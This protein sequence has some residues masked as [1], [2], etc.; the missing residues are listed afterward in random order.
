MWIWTV[1]QGFEE[2]W[3][4]EDREGV[5]GSEAAIIDRKI[6]AG[7]VGVGRGRAC[8]RMHA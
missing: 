8:T 5:V 1:F 4:L 6:T 7:L 2:F 3:R